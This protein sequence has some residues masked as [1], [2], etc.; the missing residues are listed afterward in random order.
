MWLSHLKNYHYSFGKC[1]DDKL[2]TSPWKEFNLHNFVYINISDI[3]HPPI[4]CTI[5]HCRR[6]SIKWYIIV[7]KTAAL[8]WYSIVYVN[9]WKHR[10]ELSH[11][12]ARLLLSEP[13]NIRG[14]LPRYLFIFLFCFPVHY[15][16]L[17]IFQVFSLTF[18]RSHSV[19]L[20]LSLTIFH[21]HTH[22]RVGSGYKIQ[23][24]YGRLYNG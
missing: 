21:I 17:Y 10:Y 18:S 11:I 16:F 15:C 2:I 3:C 1:W 23:S 22:I 13:S 4:S 5:E 14:L 19:S 7:C 9:I 24:K 8:T 20:F 6:W 12:P